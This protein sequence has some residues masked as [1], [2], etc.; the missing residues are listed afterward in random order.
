[1]TAFA[2]GLLVSIAHLYAGQ[3]LVPELVGHVTVGWILVWHL[4]RSLNALI[5]ITCLFIF[6]KIAERSVNWL[7]RCLTE[8]NLESRNY[9]E[10][11]PLSNFYK[12]R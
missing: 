4:W 2:T 3:S 6:R 7:F 10:L 1:M 11:K 9:V 5:L 12:S 8:D